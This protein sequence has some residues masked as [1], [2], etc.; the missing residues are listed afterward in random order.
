MPA[1]EAKK[2]E[3]Y[4]SS[5]TDPV[6]RAKSV[7][8]RLCGSLTPRNLYQKTYFAPTV[9]HQTTIE[10]WRCRACGLTF[11]PGTDEEDLY[12]YY[13]RLIELPRLPRDPIVMS[14][15]AAL[16][17]AMEPMIPSKRLLD[18]GC[19][20]GEMVEVAV[21]RG[22]DVLGVE[23]SEAAVE[24]CLKRG[25]P[26]KHLDFLSSDVP[27]PWG[28]IIVSETPERVYRNRTIRAMS[29]LPGR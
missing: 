20:A 1:P 13:R 10:L 6:E 22:W 3:S 5:Q 7:S 29:S 2:R 8:C 4:G 9:G 27:A 23:S 28:L 19:G 18:V 11:Y 25:L 17:A 15:L 26:V 24:L 14:R 16:L 12:G 21:A